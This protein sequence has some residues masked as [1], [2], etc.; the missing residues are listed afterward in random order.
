M[1][2]VHVMLLKVVLMVNLT[3]MVMD[4]NVFLVDG[5]VMDHLNSVMLEFFSHLLFGTLVRNVGH[6][7]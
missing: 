5:I 4:Q 1:L 2:K 7:L 3:A 6:F